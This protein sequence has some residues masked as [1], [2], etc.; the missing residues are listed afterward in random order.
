MRL[1]ARQMSISGITGDR[2]HASDRQS[3]NTKAQVASIELLKTIQ[4]VRRGSGAAASPTV[5]AQRFDLWRRA[6]RSDV[7]PDRHGK[8]STGSIRRLGSP[9]CCAAS[10]IILPRGST[11]SS[12][13]IGSTAK[14]Q[15]QPPDHHPPRP[16]PDAYEARSQSGRPHVQSRLNRIPHHIGQPAPHR[17]DDIGARGLW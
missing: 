3:L 17:L 9:T 5:F 1:A 7:H 14:P 11:S 12:P 4:T 15:P 2:L 13:G 6:G 10:P 16:W 8:N